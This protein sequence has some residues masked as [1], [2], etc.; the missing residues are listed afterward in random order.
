MPVSRRSETLAERLGFDLLLLGRS[1]FRRPWTAPFAYP[2]MAVR[3]VAALVRRRP[4]AAV[5]VAPPFVA[6]LVAV[7]IMVV[8]RGRLAV[9][10]HSGALLDRRWRWAVPILAWLCRRSEL[11]LV[12][13][14]DLG[15]RLR[16]M[17]V[18]TATVPDPLPRFDTMLPPRQPGNRVV[19]I[20]GW[21]DDEPIESLVDA[22]RG[23]PWQLRI[24]GRPR[25]ALDLPPNVE[26]TGFLADDAFV[27]AVA[28][29]DV[30]VVLTTRDATLLSGAW[31]ALALGRPLVLSATKA[32]RA[33]FGPGPTYVE[34][35]PAGI[36]EGI[37]RV[38]AEPSAATAATVELRD[39]FQRD[40]DAALAAVATRL[41]RPRRSRP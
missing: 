8:L 23:K 41:L 13:L 21:G 33:T 40:N 6:P 3:T 12:T 5:V 35:T 17:G 34:S 18:E 25:R 2:A 1:G 22:A 24:T 26:L 14:D 37:Q 27:R 29:A 16:R 28:D 20:C 39:R 19:A 11:A 30:V 15:S 31:E 38:L 7:P 4:R 36:A 9:D 10:I 32:L